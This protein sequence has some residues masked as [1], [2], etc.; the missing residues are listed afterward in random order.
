MIAN[1]G[2]EVIQVANGFGV[3]GTHVVYMDSRVDQGL[4]I[5]PEGARI[6][7]PNASIP[8]REPVINHIWNNE[9]YIRKV[10]SSTFK[11]P[12]RGAEDKRTDS[13]L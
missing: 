9:W 1:Y 5:P 6:V 7:S 4:G 10:V 13:I 2:E 8:S 12:I 11:A 3:S